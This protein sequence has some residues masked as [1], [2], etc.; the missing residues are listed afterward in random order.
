MAV[1]NG[2]NFGE[3][4]TY[5]NEAVRGY[6]QFLADL[7]A[8]G[9]TPAEQTGLTRDQCAQLMAAGKAAMVFLHSNG[10]TS[11]MIGSPAL[12]TV[13][14][15][16]VVSLPVQE[17]GQDW[18]TFGGGFMWA[19]PAKDYTDTQLAYI[20]DLLKYMTSE[21]NQ[22]SY[23]LFRGFLLARQSYMEEIVRLVN[24]DPGVQASYVAPLY[25]QWI[26]IAQNNKTSIPR[27]PNTTVYRMG[28]AAGV[29]VIQA[30]QT[31]DDAVK[32][33]EDYFAANKK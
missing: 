3:D 22:V 4:F 15:V 8:D 9:S 28:L 31:V 27:D 29:E 14:Q 26:T 11:Y 10:I 18:G 16:G 19:V 25:P 21:D 7:I 32:A 23:A 20:E 2:L 13:D 5:D 30:G 6:Y 24:E 12:L 17:A 1:A 33:A